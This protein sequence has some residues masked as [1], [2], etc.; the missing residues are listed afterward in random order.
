MNL[1]EHSGQEEQEPPTGDDVDGADGEKLVYPIRDEPWAG[2]DGG[3]ENGLAERTGLV[4]TGLVLRSIVRAR[5]LSSGKRLCSSLNL[6][7][8]SGTGPGCVS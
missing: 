2:Q 5:V 8:G 4:R 6:L 7:M 3:T 1:A